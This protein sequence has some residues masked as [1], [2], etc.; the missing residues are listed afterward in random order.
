MANHTRRDRDA[1]RVATEEEL[2]SKTIITRSRR[3]QR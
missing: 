3:V 1:L 2:N